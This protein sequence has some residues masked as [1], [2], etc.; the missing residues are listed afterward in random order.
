MILE[1]IIEAAVKFTDVGSIDIE[2]K[3]PDLELVAEKCLLPVENAKDNSFL[4][5]KISDKSLGIS[6]A[7]LENLFEPY[8]QLDNPNKSSLFRSIA[9]ATIKNIIR[10]LK[11]NVW[12]DSQPMQGTTYNVIIPA[13]K[14]IQSENEWS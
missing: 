10:V 12:V 7:E 5:F 9:F 6:N 2:V 11:G 13:E 14:V 1:N 8:A 3:H 4:M